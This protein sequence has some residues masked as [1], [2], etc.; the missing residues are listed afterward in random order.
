MDSDPY[1][2]FTVSKR[3]CIDHV[4]K[5]M[6]TRLRNLKKTTKG[7]GGRGKL[8]AKLIDELSIYY[9]LAIR[10]NHD[11]VDKMRKEIWATLLHKI[12]TDDKP[13]HNNCPVGAN[14]WCSWQV[15]KST[16]QLSTYTHKTPMSRDVFRAIKPIYTEL[17]R[18][19]LLSR[20]LGGFT[21][22]CNKSFNSVLWAMAPKHIH[23][24]RKSVSIAADIATCNFNSGLRGIMEIMQVLQ[25]AIGRTCF[26]FCSRADTFRVSRAEKAMTE[27]ARQ[28]R[29]DTISTR[30]AADDDLENMEGLF[31]GAGIAD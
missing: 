23:S 15:A 14:S 4:Q 31:Y 6:G 3:E 26:E 13:Q 16:G 2:N 12:S 10:R 19:D 24:G 8:T 27:E 25:L 5:R 9:G 11:S 22:N 1:G 30:K 28:A 21:Q 18:D 29:R 7:L 20:C 17:S